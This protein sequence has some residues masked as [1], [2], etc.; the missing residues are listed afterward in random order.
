M[1][2]FKAFA[3]A[4]LAAFTL[5]SCDNNQD[6]QAVGTDGWLKGDQNEKFEELANQMGGFSRTMVEVAYRY[7]ELY[8][9]GQD[10]NWDYADHQLEHLLETLEDGMKRRPARADNAQHFIDNEIAMME[11]LILQGDKNAFLEGFRTFTTGCNSCHAKENE[12]FITIKEPQVRTS[13]VRF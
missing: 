9:A 3:I 4:G 12:S 10:E 5:S 7:S 13:P 11:D 1:R 6:Q 8:W 2:I